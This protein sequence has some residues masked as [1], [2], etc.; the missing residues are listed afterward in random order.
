MIENDT[1]L[2]RRFERQARAI[3]QAYGS[4]LSSDK[5]LDFVRASGEAICPTCG[6]IY[7]DHPEIREG[8]CKGLVVAC[9]GTLLKL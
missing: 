6:L 9:G 8:V 5:A 7:L 1:I 4:I 3:A 2:K